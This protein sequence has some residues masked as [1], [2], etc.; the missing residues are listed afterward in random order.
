M[1]K[2]ELL[3][4]L[5]KLA[6]DLGYRIRYEFGDFSGGNCVLNDQK[7]ILINKRIPPEARIV[8]LARIYSSMNLE[9]VIMKPAVRD[10]IEDEKARLAITKKSETTLPEE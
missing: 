1:R 5:E 4:E 2:Q 10:Y 6:T 9:S 3:T 8:I 7:M